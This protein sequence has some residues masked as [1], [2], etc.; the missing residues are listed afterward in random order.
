[1]AALPGPMNAY[2]K[3]VRD[4]PHALKRVR[5]HYLAP[6]RELLTTLGRMAQQRP[7]KQVLFSGMGSSLFA[8]YPA[9]R[10][11]S[12]R[13]F[14]AATVETSELL[15]YQLGGI[16]EGALVFLVSQSGETIEV[17]RLLQRVPGRERLVGVTNVP[18]S[19][20]GRFCALT[21]PMEAGPQ[22]AVSART[23]HNTVAVLLLA[24]EAIA[25]QSGLIDRLALA[26]DAMASL[27]GG[28][29]TL[30]AALDEFVGSPTSASLLARGPS[31]A[32]A[33]QGALNLK[34][35]AK[36]AAEPM[37]AAQFRHGPIEVATAAHV[38]LLFAPLGAT[39]TLLRKLAE[40][41]LGFGTRVVFVTDSQETLE[42]HGDGMFVARH[43]HL[44]E[45][46]APLVNLVPVQL[47]ANARAERLGLE[48]G[49][50]G[51]ASAVMRVE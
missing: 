40:E 8:A 10:Y 19:A 6:G 51:K 13:G 29:D 37:S 25:G 46:L 18:G 24:A 30:G 28:S 9:V 49:R 16:P 12:E 11:L 2:L 27:L 23:Y 38:S 48:V 47:L 43:P 7:I 22:Q 3:E 33:S 20:L 14:S 44:E 36:F 1:M 45:N 35:V 26:A 31:L 39:F 42:R 5:D 4:Q 21:L 32:T 34:E 15:H 50:L 17:E 41:L